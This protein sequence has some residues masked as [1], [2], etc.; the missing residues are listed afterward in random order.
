MKL[1]LIIKTAIILVAACCTRASAQDRDVLYWA[2]SS[3]LT[4]P[5]SA[6]LG[7]FD[8]EGYRALTFLEFTQQFDAG[9]W[10]LIAIRRVGRLDTTTQVALIDRL[11]DH[12]ARGG[13]VLVHLAEIEQMP[14]LQRF[15]G[16]NGAE[17]LVAPLEAGPLL[18]P[19]HPAGRFFLEV[20]DE[21]MTHEFGARLAPGADSKPF[22]AFDDGTIASI[23]ALEGQIIVNGW[24]PDGWDGGLG[25]IVAADHLRWLL[26]CPADLDGSGS[27]DLFDFLEFQ[28]LFDAGDPSA[29]W[30]CYDGRL[31]VFDF[32]AFFNAFQAGCP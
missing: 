16:L 6:A 3:A 8:V 14:M 32:L 28:R 18:D 27:L 24:E 13:R 25:I 9:P 23:L 19:S 17:D 31:D 26:G 12:L 22:F 29:D 30:F 21:P 1:H 4:D 2:D 7:G 10:R 11:E 5:I 20:A 15:F